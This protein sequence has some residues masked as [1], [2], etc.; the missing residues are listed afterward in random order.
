MNKRFS[1]GE[2]MDSSDLKIF[3]A[4]VEQGGIVNASAFLHKVPSAIST[5]IKQLE[6]NLDTQLFT[7]EHRKLF[8]TAEGKILYEYA[9]DILSLT[10]RAERHVKHR[11]PGGK[12]KLGAMDSMASSRLPEPLSN[13]YIRYPSIQLE[14]ITGISQFLSDTIKDNN[15]DATFIADFPTDDRFERVTVF[16]EELVVVAPS[17]HPPITSPKDIECDTLLVFKEGCSYRSRLF[18]W[19]RDFQVQPTRVATMSSYPV[20]LASVASGMGIGIVPL[21]LIEDFK[22]S[23][24]ISIHKIAEI[25]PI[26]TDLIW[27]KGHYSLNIESLLE[28][29]NVPFFQDE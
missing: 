28:V 13:L 2:L 27:K 25:E 14:L 7:R 23:N 1:F 12:F 17:N 16:K 9:L 4:V 18:D 10:E 11:S 15:L 5:R 3:V 19:Y 26:T 6:S 21:S 24:S 22:Y 8:L 20:I 29:L